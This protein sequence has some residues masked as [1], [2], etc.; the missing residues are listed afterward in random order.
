VSSP[1]TS[2]SPSLNRS[3]DKIRGIILQ[4]PGGC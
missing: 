4:S 3:G 1:G 2:S